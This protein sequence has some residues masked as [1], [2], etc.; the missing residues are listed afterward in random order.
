MRKTLEGLHRIDLSGI[1]PAHEWTAALEDH[2]DHAEHETDVALPVEGADAGVWLVVA[3]AGG[4]EASSLVIRTDLRVVLQRLGEKVRVYVTD[5]QGRSVRGAYVTVSDGSQH[6]GPR[7][8]GRPRRLRGAGR[9]RD[10]V[11]RRLLRGP[12][13]DRAVG[14]PVFGPRDRF[15]NGPQA[16]RPPSR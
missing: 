15:P 8:D 3:K 4:H 16:G 7:A 2:A 14:A 6:P 9:R 11:R 10:A 12:L 13:R 1:V 5:A